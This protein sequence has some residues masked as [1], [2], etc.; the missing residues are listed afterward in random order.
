LWGLFGAWVLVVFGVSSVPHLAAPEVGALG[1]DKL[2]HVLEY[3]VLGLLYRRAAGVKGARAAW[4]GALV[5]LAVGA[6]DETWQGRVAGREQDF[7]DAL[8]DVLGAAL[9]SFGWGAWTRWRQRSI[10]S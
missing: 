7:F 6:L 9:G 8:A 1:L 10:L 4:T 3:A 5:G 2:F